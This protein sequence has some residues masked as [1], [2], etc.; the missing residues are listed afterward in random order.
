MDNRTDKL[1]LIFSNYKTRDLN[2]WKVIYLQL[3]LLRGDTFELEPTHL[4][5]GHLRDIKISAFV[6]N[7]WKF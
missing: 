6:V 2:N 4:E 7:F 1:N 5:E 3:E